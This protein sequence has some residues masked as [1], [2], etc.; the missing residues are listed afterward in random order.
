MTKSTNG[1]LYFL[2]LGVDSYPNIKGRILTSKPD[3]TDMK[4]LV[5]D[6]KHCP[7]GIDVDPERQHIYWTNMGVGA[8]ND[9]SIQRCALNGTNI[10]TV[11]PQDI[12]HTPKQLKIAV[13]SRKVYW[14]DREGMRVFRADLT[15]ENVEV[16][17]KV[18]DWEKGEEMDIHE[19]WCVGITVDEEHSHFYWTQKGPSK[20]GKGTIWR[21]PIDFK[22]EETAETRTDIELLFDELPEPVD[23][24]IDHERQILYWTDRGDMPF[25]NSVSCAYVGEPKGKA[26]T[27][28]AKGVS[29][30]KAG[31]VGQRK[32]L[33]KKLHETCGIA[34][35]LP[36]ERMFFG[37]LN[38][39][40][41]ESNLDGSEKVT[42]FEDVGVATGIAY[43][44]DVD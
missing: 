5:T 14:S 1:R 17:V 27:A 37:D 16:L 29:A 6:L 12:T 40:I 24:E 39:S 25:G 19:H 20:G 10:E 34:L 26:T 22:S 42:L 30:E 8:A 33:L 44:P 11:I 2:D 28:P 23:L 4:T 41:Y 13:K 18:S 3:G 7:D 36:R 31:L 43:L 35:D 9:G 21:A 32:L 38:G 15:G